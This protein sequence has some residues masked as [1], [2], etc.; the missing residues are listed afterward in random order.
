MVMVKMECDRE[1]SAFINVAPTVRFL[2]PT[3]RARCI[4]CFDVGRLG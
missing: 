2:F 3:F 4:L 1:E